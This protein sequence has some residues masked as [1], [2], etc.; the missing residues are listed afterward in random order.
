[1]MMGNSSCYVMCGFMN[2]EEILRFKTFIGFKKS[3]LHG[4]TANNWQGINE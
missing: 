3:K 1:M 2:V 4:K